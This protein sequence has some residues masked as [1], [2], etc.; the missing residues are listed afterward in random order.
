MNTC[1]KLTAALLFF[2]FSSNIVH[3]QPAER[4]QIDK[5]LGAD[6]SFLPELESKGRKFY[7]AG[8]EKD[9]IQILKE[10]GFN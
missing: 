6:I 5:M 9:A 4:K 1:F 10:K 3:A 2:V 7:D 8:V